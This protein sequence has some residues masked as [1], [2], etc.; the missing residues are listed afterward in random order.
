M[1][2]FF[3][4]L[5]LNGFP[6]GA[7]IK[8]YED[9][10]KGSLQSGW[11]EEQ[12][13]KTFEHQYNNSNFYKKFISTTNVQ[14][15]SDIPIISKHDLMGSYQSKLPTL[16]EN[17][18]MYVSRTSGSTGTPMMFARE[19]MFH[20]MVWLSVNNIYRSN[21]FTVNDKQAR[22][23]GI[24]ISRRA[25]YKEKFKD[26]LANRFRFVVF[27]LNEEVMA[28]WVQLFNRKKFSVIYGYT[29]SI[30]QFGRYLLNKNICL[31]DICPSLKVCVVTSE[32][33]SDDEHVLLKKAFGVDV[34]N[35]YGASEV[36][37]IGFRKQN[38]WD[39]SDEMVY[40]EV[41]DDNGQVLKDG[42][43]GRLLVTLLHN[44]AT[45]IIRYQIGDL[46]SL[47]RNNGKTR[48]TSL[49]GRLNDLAIL[50]SGKKVPGLTFYYAVHEAI[51][52][53]VDIV[54]H[55][56]V[57]KHLDTF[58]VNVVS[59]AK[60]NEHQVRSIKLA[61]DKYLDSGLDVS[62]NEVHEIKRQGN[63]KFKH[64]ISEV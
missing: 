50:S 39:V 51:G 25:Y 19:R 45:P 23:Y 22:F 11:Q 55:Q 9:I 33:C 59:K 1:F 5:K 47:E 17:S 28:S 34:Y 38:F 13:W 3:S 63:G 27:N 18:K 4:I 8:E 2:D 60:I 61:F 48:I 52:K 54:E 44:K 14:N 41:V 20:V 32:M 62:V 36:C 42:E 7:A 15:W 35:E 58:V 16:L 57:Q 26:V 31:L 40:L 64:F 43:S 10:L 29:N 53:D 56:V 37:V 30:V 46:A 24:P 49:Q 21:G 6:V 12:I